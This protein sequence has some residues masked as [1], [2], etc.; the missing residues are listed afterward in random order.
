MQPTKKQ[1]MEIF[2]GIQV[3]RES[4]EAKY[5]RASELTD[6]VLQRT[7]EILY[8]PCDSKLGKLICVRPLLHS[9]R[10]HGITALQKRVGGYTSWTNPIIRFK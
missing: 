2:K 1:K 10:H 3:I 8:I 4:Y 5:P 9:G 7:C 6:Q